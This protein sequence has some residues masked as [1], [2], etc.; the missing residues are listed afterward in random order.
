MVT[1]VGDVTDVV[2]VMV[3]IAGVAGTSSL[4]RFGFGFGFFGLDFELL[5]FFFFPPASATSPDRIP[6]AA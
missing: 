4:L 1:G 3:A 6:A 2:V 5:W